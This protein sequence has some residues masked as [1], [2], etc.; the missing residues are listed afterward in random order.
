MNPIESSV[1]SSKKLKQASPAFFL[2]NYTPIFI[3]S[4]AVIGCALCIPSFSAS[5]A[6]ISSGSPFS[7]AIHSTKQIYGL[8]VAM[9]TVGLAFILD[10]C[11]VHSFV[12]ETSESYFEHLIIFLSMIIP[13]IVFL[14]QDSSCPGCLKGNIDYTLFDMMMIASTLAVVSMI[15]RKIR[16]EDDVRISSLLCIFSFLYTLSIVLRNFMGY[17]DYTELLV[18]FAIVYFVSIM[19]FLA[20]I[21]LIVMEIMRKRADGIVLNADRI[22]L[23][24][25]LAVLLAEVCRFAAA[26]P[27]TSIAYWAAF[28]SNNILAFLIIQIVFTVFLAVVPT[29]M[30]S[31]LR[32]SRGRMDALRMSHETKAPLD[33]MAMGLSILNNLQ[34]QDNKS[35]QK[36]QLISTLLSMCQDITHAMSRPLDE[37]SAHGG[38]DL[39]ALQ[40]KKQTLVPFLRRQAQVFE[41]VAS[42]N[43][44]TLNFQA[45]DI[46]PNAYIAVD[47]KLMAQ[48]FLNLLSHLLKLSPR[49][50]SIEIKAMLKPSND[51][52]GQRLS[53]YDFPR[54]DSNV[55]QY[56]GV[57]SIR[58]RENGVAIISSKGA[59]IAESFG[60]K[61]H[62]LENELQVFRSVLEL[63]S[64]IVELHGG[65]LVNIQSSFMAGRAYTIELPLFEPIEDHLPRQRV[66]FKREPT[67]HNPDDSFL[68]RP[69][70]A[71]N[72]RLPSISRKAASRT[73]RHF[74]VAAD[75]IVTRKTVLQLLVKNGCT[76][77][78]VRDGTACVNLVQRS[79][80]EE[81]QEYDAVLVD[82][83]MPNLDGPSTIELIKGMGYHGVV[84]GMTGMGDPFSIQEFM[85]KGADDVLV[86]PIS[87]EKLNRVFVKLKGYK[88][89]SQLPEASIISN[90]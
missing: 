86:K 55:D 7:N 9:L 67:I 84:Y 54:N 23:L 25:S 24:L 90:V 22:G 78:I 85:S 18:T 11:F 26:P 88:P 41:Q 77:D 73:A 1:T 56:L 75:A 80:F 69:S 40:M 45:E 35:V 4:L 65:S 72:L 46:A 64:R 36:A 66:S 83:C 17:I 10:L 12:F 14:S 30:E 87:D 5:A 48:V 79:L 74:L 81:S 3:L 38:G 57:V 8:Y 76:H 28:G 21:T 37:R 62:S 51:N 20:L 47:S 63:S 27:S 43:L 58:I 15:Y 71:G 82:Y 52:N 68:R 44:V 61:E 31:A 70:F 60:E 13:P 89:P 32:Q 6:Y 49:R 2:H 59:S 50:G 34:S 39:F 42:E 16:S 29:R 19:S 33:V 53:V